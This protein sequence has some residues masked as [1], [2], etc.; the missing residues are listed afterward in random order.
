LK[1]SAWNFGSDINADELVSSTASIYEKHPSSACRGSLSAAYLL[2]ALQ[3]LSGQ[4]PPIAEMI[5]RTRRAVHAKTLITWLVERDGPL[6]E[7]V[8]RHPDVQKALALERET[9]H[10][11][12]TTV[13]PDDW[14]LFRTTD[15]SEATR[16]AAAWKENNSVQLRDE[17]Q[18]Q[19]APAAVSVVLERY[20]ACKLKGDE[21]QAQATYQEAL[22]KGLPLP[23][24]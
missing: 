20:W 4:H 7:Q 8:R 14:A 19:V 21:A 22:R 1:K 3:Q 10:R 11:F 23:A 24:L 18:F 17:L 16:I 6:A 13:G 5:G 15:P 12:A 2:R 9:C